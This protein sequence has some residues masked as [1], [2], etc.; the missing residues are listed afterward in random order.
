M[1]KKQIKKL[2]ETM[3]LIQVEWLHSLLSEVDGAQITTENVV[4]YLSTE[5][6]TFLNRQF[7]LS[8]M[9]DRWILKQLKRNPQ[10]KTYR[11]LETLYNKKQKT[12]EVLWTSM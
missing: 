7:E 5:T 8:F 3:R 10:I 1:K 12:K 6:H 11:E 4:E 2:K 9:S